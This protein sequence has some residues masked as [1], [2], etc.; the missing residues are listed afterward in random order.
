MEGWGEGFVQGPKNS[1]GQRPDKEKGEGT[2]EDGHQNIRTIAA[3]SNQH[4][5][6]HWHQKDILW[7][8]A[9]S[10]SR[11]YGLKDVPSQRF[12]ASIL[13][14]PRV[15]MHLALW[16]ERQ[17]T[18]SPDAKEVTQP[19]GE[20]GC[21]NKQLQLSA[22]TRADQEAHSF[23]IY[24]LSTYTMSDAARGYVP[25][26]FPHREGFNRGSR[27]ESIY[28]ITSGQTCQNSLISAMGWETGKN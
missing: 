8:T 12:L 13:I 7:W 3:C 28:I 11:A 19:S 15:T 5:F 25:K 17:I 21:V 24:S 22:S 18:P 27:Q 2:V 10:T 6:Y 4:L 23:D 20:A 26:S 14:D 16:T 1:A 9:A